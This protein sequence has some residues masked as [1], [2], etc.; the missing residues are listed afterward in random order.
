MRILL[1]E[2][3]VAL[4]ESLAWGLRAEGYVVQIIRDGRE[5]LWH[6]REGEYDLIILDVM[7]PSLD[8]YQICAGLREAGIWTPVL[9]LTALDDALDQAE[10]LDLGADDY[11]TKPFAYP[12]LLARLRALLRRRATERPAVLT[13]AGVSL[14][15]ATRKVTRNGR[16]IALTPGEVTVLEYLLRAGGRSVS[17]VEL[18]EHCWDASDETDPAV[19]EVRV[20]H[21]RRKLDAPFGT[22]SIQTVRGAGYRIGADDD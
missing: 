12:V 14:D 9:M 15:P 16:Q 1:I 5:G 2:D 22:R 18:L 7:L 19:V 13:A 11:L 17:K 20:H 10:G 4:A 6:A 3:D 8:G 21:L